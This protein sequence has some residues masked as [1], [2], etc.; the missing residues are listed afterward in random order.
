M[1]KVD[2]FGLMMAIFLSLNL[3]DGSGSIE[4]VGT[5]TATKRDQAAGGQIEPEPRNP[6]RIIFLASFVAQ[7]V[8]D[9]DK[10]LPPFGN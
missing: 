10:S 4:S 9:H 1:S 6:L 5:E 8:Y 3:T 7:K 2:W